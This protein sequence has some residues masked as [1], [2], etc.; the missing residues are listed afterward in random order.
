MCFFGGLAGLPGHW[1]TLVASP[2]GFF[3]D[4]VYR[5]PNGS[6]IEPS[7]SLAAAAHLRIPP[8]LPECFGGDILRACRVANHPG[9]GAGYAVVVN[10]EES[11]EIETVVECNSLNRFAWRVHV[12]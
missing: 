8:E 10:V 11:F 6:S 5:H 4:L 1:Q 7:H 12:L 2:P 3:S 9:H